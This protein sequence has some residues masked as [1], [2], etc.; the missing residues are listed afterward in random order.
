[1]MVKSSCMGLVPL[2]RGS[3]EFSCPFHYVV[4]LA[5]YDQGS[6]TTSDIEPAG[7]LILDLADPRTVRNKFLLLI[8]H[9]LVFCYSC[10]MG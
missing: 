7:A 8:S 9:L 3:T 5:V 1:M 4:K 10:W 2:K 6:E